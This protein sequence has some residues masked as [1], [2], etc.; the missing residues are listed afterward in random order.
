MAYKHDV[1]LSYTTS[2]PVGDWVHEHLLCFFESYL[3]QALNRPDA[4]WF[5]DREGISSGDSWPE[6]I[7]RSLA[8]SRC[9]VAVWSPLYFKSE[10]CLHECAVMR[11]RERQLGYRTMQNPSGLILPINVFDGEHFLDFAKKIKWLDCRKFL[12][13]SKVFKF[14]PRFMELEDLMIEWISNDVAKAINNAPP[15]SE[16]W[17]TKQW[18]DDAINNIHYTTGFSFKPPFLE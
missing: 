2:P 10:W 3:A 15:W 16:K 17:E 9:M 13:Q 8:R 7:N 5:V 6:R 11:H 4:N 12:R 18:I 1:F 14:T